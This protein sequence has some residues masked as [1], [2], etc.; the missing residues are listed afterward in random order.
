MKSIQLIGITL[1]LSGCAATGDNL[2]GNV[3]KAGQVNTIQ[4]AK[5][6]EILSVLPAKIEVDNSKQKQQAQV[7]GGILGA[8]AGGLAG[9]FGTHGNPYATAGTT[10]A[11]GAIGAAA[12]SM[13]DDKVLVEGV[14]IT[15][16]YNN[17]T[18]NSVQVG[19]AC[20]FT[21]GTTSMVSTSP[22]ETRIQA[23]K[24][25]PAEKT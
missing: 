14:S 1:I 15:Y 21:R 13:V 8:I 3:Y 23:N 6:I 12:G 16:I 17:Q 25:C 24:T 4:A 7:G 20:E 2:K 18:L 22:T 19:R 10:L 5:S 9:G 11:G